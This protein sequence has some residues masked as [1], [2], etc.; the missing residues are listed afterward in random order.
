MGVC[1]DGEICVS[2][3]CL[4]I[5]R[6]YTCSGKSCATSMSGRVG[7][8]VIWQTQGSHARVPNL[9]P[10]R[11]LVICFTVLSRVENALTGIVP[12]FDDGLDFGM[13]RHNS[14]FAS[15]CFDTPR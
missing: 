6:G 4:D 10:E 13:D 11:I 15:L 1:C 7:S 2:H 12:S 3:D 9:I 8:K 5:L 14:V